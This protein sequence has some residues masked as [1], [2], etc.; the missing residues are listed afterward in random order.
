MSHSR[1]VWVF[2]IVEG[3]LG[4]VPCEAGVSYQ[5]PA[6]GWRYSYGGTFNAPVVDGGFVGGVGPAGYGRAN[7]SEALDGNWLHDQSDKWDGSG[8]GD[9]GPIPNGPAPGGAAARTEGATS[10]IRVQDTG[11]PEVHGYTQAQ[12]PIN[13]NRRVYFGH[14]MSQDGPFGG[15]VAGRDEQRVLDNGITISF[16]MRIPNTAP[17]DPIYTGTAQS[18]LIQPWFVSPEGD[19]NDNGYVDGADYVVWRDHLGTSFQL[20][21]EVQGITPGM[22]TPEDYTEWR[23]RF[24]NERLGRGYLVHDDGRGMITILQNNNTFGNEF[25]PN[26]GVDGTIAFSLVTSKDI[27]LLC[28]AAPGSTA[29]SGSG[30]GGLMMNNRSGDSPNNFVDA[31]DTAQTLNLLPIVD[32]ALK[33][34]HEFWIT[35]ADNGAT[36]GT[37]TVNVYMDGSAT[38]TTFQVT[39]SSSGNGAY[40]NSSNPFI[41]FGLSSTDLFGAFDM[42]FYAYKLGVIT[43]VAAGIGSGGATLPEPGTVAFILVTLLGLCPLRL[44]RDSAR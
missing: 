34:W 37:H 30:S 2:A 35:I 22:V 40:A 25:D 43:P 5:D 20:T 3:L 16:R 12:D 18:P 21:N 6:G 27:Q 38:P 44:S 10:Y 1:F 41:E 31:F 26:N 19:Y 8:P 39:V 14:N 17:M 7:D 32:Q 23:A 15:P 9:T 11:N 28:A 42:D 4:S 24:G 36:A 33:N 13:P 29:C